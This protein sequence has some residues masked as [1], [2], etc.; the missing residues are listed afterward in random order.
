MEGSTTP[1]EA[2]SK[3]ESSA[4]K[5]DGRIWLFYRRRLGGEEVGCDAEGEQQNPDFLC[6]NHNLLTPLIPNAAEHIDPPMP[7]LWDKGLI[8]QFAIFGCSSVCNPNVTK[9]MLLKP[10][11]NW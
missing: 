2:N 4:A 6:I 9:T 7:F 11:I 8:R 5:I 10:R 1:A 3:G